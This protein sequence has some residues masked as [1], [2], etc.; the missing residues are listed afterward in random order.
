MKIAVPAKKTIK[1][2]LI[3][4]IVHSTPFTLF[5]KPSQ[6]GQSNPITAIPG[7]FQKT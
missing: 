1:S 7:H 6:A 3:S 2:K 5:S 4:D